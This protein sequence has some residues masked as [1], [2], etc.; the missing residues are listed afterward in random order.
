MTRPHIFSP[1]LGV[2]TSPNRKTTSEQLKPISG[3]HDLGRA[4]GW[5]G[6][7]VFRFTSGGTDK[8]MWGAP[9][10]SVNPKG[11]PHN[12]LKMKGQT[13]IRTAMLALTATLWGGHTGARH[14]HHNFQVRRD[15]H[16]KR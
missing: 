2:A 6:W 11:A 16:T 9:T 15:I 5:T 10:L 1:R 4:E 13:M 3:R 14:P 12:T 8:A 7:F